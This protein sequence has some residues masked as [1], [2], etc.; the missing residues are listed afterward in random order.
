MINP[1]IV[2]KVAISS[3]SDFLSTILNMA[4]ISPIPAIL[5]IIYNSMLHH[6]NH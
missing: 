2:T 1:E 4:V 5:K 6:Q 3:L